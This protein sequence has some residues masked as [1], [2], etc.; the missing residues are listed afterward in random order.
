MGPL[1]CSAILT[2]PVAGMRQHLIDA[3]SGHYIPTHKYLDVAC[4]FLTHCLGS[5]KGQKKISDDATK[6]GFRSHPII[7]ADLGF[8]LS[9]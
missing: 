1:T 4:Q 8:N 5:H 2:Y 9:Q 6:K 7:L 3:P